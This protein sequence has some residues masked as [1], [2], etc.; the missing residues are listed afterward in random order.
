MKRSPI[1]VILYHYNDNIMFISFEGIDFSGK[2]T[3]A[4]LLVEFLKERQKPVLFLREPGGTPISEKIREILLD[5]IHLGMS[6]VA[7]LFLFSAARAQL[8]RE[9]IRPALDKKVIVICDRFTDSTVAYQGYGRGIG[10]DAVK[11]IN[12]IATGSLSPDLTFFVD[13][14]VEEV[15]RRQAASGAAADRMESSGSE[16]FEK[17]RNGYWSLAQETPDRFVVV[18][19]TR[20]IGEIQ[21]E[22][23]QIIMK[24]VVEG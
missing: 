6:G 24:R 21:D 11:I 9:V 10:L 16:F 12:E 22:M 1:L 2:T 8:V 4:K 17:V 23:R 13:I 18:N 7:E 14:P 20:P 3:H 19:G 5:K 15:Y